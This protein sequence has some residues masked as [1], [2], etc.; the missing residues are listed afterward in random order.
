MTFSYVVAAQD[1]D[2]PLGCLEESVVAGQRRWFS[3]SALLCSVVTPAE[4]LPPSS[5][6]LNR[7]TWTY[8]TGFRGGYQDAQRVGVP[9]LW[10]WTV[11][12]EVVE[13]GEAPGETL[14]PL[15]VLKGATR[16]LKR[17]VW[18][19]DGVIGQ[20]KSCEY[21]GSVQGHIGW[22]SEQSGLMRWVPAR[23]LNK[24]VFKAPCNPNHT[25]IL[26]LWDDSIFLILVYK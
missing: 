25:V 11:R 8:W 17:H 22:G 15:P 21:P 24:M 16:E 26:W 18:Q 5:E 23:Q 1:M 6:I 4:V 20:Q 2:D 19:G 12:V 3:S 7:R 13:H 9:A 10:R 14:E